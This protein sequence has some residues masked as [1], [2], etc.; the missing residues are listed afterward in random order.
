MFKTR[1]HPWRNDIFLYGTDKTEVMYI[2]D[3]VLFDCN[4]Q[5]IVRSLDK[6]QWIPLDESIQLSAWEN[7]IFVTQDDGFGYWA[8][9]HDDEFITLVSRSI[10]D[11]KEFGLDYIERI[12]YL[13]PLIDRVSVMAKLQLILFKFSPHLLVLLD[14]GEY[15]TIVSS[16]L[17]FKEY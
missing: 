4:F 9:S 6:G 16:Y 10:F 11:K 2:R 15:K 14:E 5:L 13:L 17:S 7:K 12:E 8:L 1:P 3:N